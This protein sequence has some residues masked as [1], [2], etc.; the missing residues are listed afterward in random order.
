MEWKFK[1]KYN[2]CY[3]P[4]SS[5]SSYYEIKFRFRKDLQ[6]SGFE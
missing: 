5:N 6:Y 1:K 3:G 2:P 4:M